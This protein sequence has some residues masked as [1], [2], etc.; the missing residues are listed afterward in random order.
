M[1]T[2][3]G[4]F[5]IEIVKAISGMI[6]GFIRANATV[7]TTKRQLKALVKDAGAAKQIF[8]ELVRIDYGSPFQ[9]KEITDAA[10]KLKAYGVETKNLVAITES[11]A[12]M[13]ALT[14]QEISGIALAYG[15]VIAK[16]RLQGEELLQF[17]ERGINLSGELQQML[18]LQAAEFYKMVTAGKISAELV[19]VAIQKMTAEGGEFANAFSETADTVDTK[20]ANLHNA[21]NS[22]NV[23]FGELFKDT[24]KG[25]LDLGTQIAQGLTRDIYRAM[26]LMSAP[27]AQFKR[28][29][30]AMNQALTETREKFGQAFD[31]NDAQQFNFYLQRRYEIAKQLNEAANKGIG[32]S[33]K[34]Q[35]TA[36]SVRQEMQKQ[37]Q[38]LQEKLALQEQIARAVQAEYNLQLEVNNLAAQQLSQRQGSD[39]QSLEQRKQTMQQI[40]RLAQQEQQIQEQGIQAAYEASLVKAREQ[41]DLQQTMLTSLEQQLGQKGQLT[42][43]EQAVLELQ[44]QQVAKA[45][46]MFDAT[47]REA[48][49]VR[50]LALARAQALAEQKKVAAIEEKSAAAIRD[51][52]RGIDRQVQSLRLVQQ[53]QQKQVAQK[54]QLLR[55]QLQI[56]S[57]EFQSAKNINEAFNAAKKKLATFNFD[58]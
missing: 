54:I 15:Q 46:E 35:I 40:I 52:N 19:T 6:G 50:Q 8:D 20:L 38:T 47:Q 37:N 10:L 28:D 29:Q 17:Q 56:A 48:E 30:Q 11:L 32:I 41:L 42:E 2:P 58:C 18:G 5:A 26:R 53:T 4:F 14:G 25:L 44:A 27:I 45:Q 3:L 57:A 9:L 22:L 1:A 33:E 13:A 16:G 51:V 12:K 31:P 49:A 43:A 39:G 23:A 24:T 21:V 36:E 55:S 7:E 34:E